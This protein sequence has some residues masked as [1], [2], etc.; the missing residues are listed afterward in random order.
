MNIRKIYVGLIAFLLMAMFYAWTSETRALSTSTQLAEAIYE[1]G[2]LLL[3]QLLLDRPNDY[4]R[5]IGIGLSQIVTA[6]QS[7]IPD[8]AE[9]ERHK[10]I[11]TER[12]ID[13]VREKFGD[14]SIRKGRDLI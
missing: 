14:N 11:T 1:D 13:K 6:D 2:Q 7:D 4:F 8:L 3:K 12:T 9:P 10:K 5:L